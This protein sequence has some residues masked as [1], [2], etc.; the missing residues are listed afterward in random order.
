[1]IKPLIYRTIIVI[2]YCTVQLIFPFQTTENKAFKTSRT[3]YP[4]IEVRESE[5]TSR[6]WEGFQLI[7]SANAGDAEAMHTLAIRYLTGKGI[8]ADT[9]KAFDMLQRSADKGYMLAL[10]NL[11]VFHHNGW[12]VEWNPFKAFTYF[13]SSAESGNRDGAYA[14]ALY[15]TENLTVKKDLPAALYWMKKAD[16]AGNRNAREVVEEIE[17]MM[18]RPSLDSSLVITSLNAA[19]QQAPS[20]TPLFDLEEGAE[21]DAR[22][23]YV[24]TEV[25]KA[26]SPQWQAR[27]NALPI[28]RDSVIIAMLQQHAEWGVPEEFA[29]LGHC[30][31]NGI[32]VKRDSAKAV[33]A[34]L[35]SARLESRRAPA[36]LNALIGNVKLIERIKQRAASGDREELFTVVSLTLTELIKFR[37]NESIVMFL[38]QSAKQG[39]LP[40]M[41]EL[42][43]VY[44]SGQAV[45]RDQEKAFGY[46][47][48]AIK[49]G[50]GEAMVKKASAVL[51]TGSRTIPQDSAVRMIEQGVLEGSLAA[52]VTLGFCYETGKGVKRK[53]GEAVRL[54]RTAL[55]RGSSTAYASLLRIYND[56][57]PE[58][59]E[60]QILEGS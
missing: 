12:G 18:A 29:V 39:Y 5:V 34:Y 2:V 60:F 16:S 45:Q 52:Q 15:F 55:Q 14:Y 36:L 56:L 3:Y 25:V 32:G 30:Y 10:Y 43:S 41:T 35:R 26:L 40:A 57:R 49:N 50:S 20:F 58:G 4:V 33:L 46:W 51:L 44:F 53:N 37:K 9:V 22:S 6:L 27:I 23:G 31:A 7:R 54:Y 42:G 28:Q 21:H 17:R 38:E 11:G 47:D 59:K 8:T 48:D 19:T 13:R 1:M 24:L